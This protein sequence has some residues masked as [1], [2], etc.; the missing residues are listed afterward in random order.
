[1]K[2]STALQQAGCNVKMGFIMMFLQQGVND[3]K[4]FNENGFVS[5][6]K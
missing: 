2:P 6:V 3:G 5:L 1:M 4:E